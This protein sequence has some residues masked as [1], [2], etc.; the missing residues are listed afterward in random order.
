MNGNFSC[1]ESGC[2]EPIVGQC[3]GYKAP[4]GRFYC[5]KHSKGRLCTS[6]AAAEVQDELEQ[7][8]DA[9]AKE[10][11]KRGQLAA[12][13]V[14]W[15]VLL[16]FLLYPMWKLLGDVAIVLWGILMLGGSIGINFMWVHQMKKKA[17]EVE[18]D[19]PNFSGYFEAWRKKKSVEMTNVL[20]GVAIAVVVGTA[21]CAILSRRRS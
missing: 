4:C 18:Q 6:C 12:I 14:G 13:S 5:A 3:M 2:S 10:I 19:L 16:F 8:Y 17:L 7:L 1:S 21:A 11:P 20:A 9:R 15:L